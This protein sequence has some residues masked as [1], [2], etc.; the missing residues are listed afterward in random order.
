MFIWFIIYSPSWSQGSISWRKLEAKL[1]QG[2]WSK[3]TYWL[4]HRAFLCLFSKTAKDHLPRNDTTCFDRIHYGHHAKCALGPSILSW[5]IY[6]VICSLFSSWNVLICWNSQINIL[7]YI[8]FSLKKIHSSFSYF[9]LWILY[10][11]YKFLQSCFQVRKQFLNCFLKVACLQTRL[12]SLIKTSFFSSLYQQQ[13]LLS[14]G[15]KFSLSLMAFHIAFILDL[16][17]VYMFYASR[18]LQVLTVY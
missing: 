5:T 6:F 14:S 2:L 16:L 10:V 8:P 12:Y 1:K 18:F 11:L 7:N 4:A 17:D 9:H 3:A 13:W 15:A